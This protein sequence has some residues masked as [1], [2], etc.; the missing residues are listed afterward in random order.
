M[1]SHEHFLSKT[2]DLLPPRTGITQIGCFSA[3]PRNFAIPIAPLPRHPRAIAYHSLYH[4]SSPYPL[5]FRVVYAD[6]LIAYY[7]TLIFV[8]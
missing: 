3:N 5:C 1:G 6:Y 8:P 4:V 2:T 7:F